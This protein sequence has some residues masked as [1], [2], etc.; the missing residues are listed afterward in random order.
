MGT[1][2]E[3]PVY[4]NLVSRDVLIL[5]SVIC[6]VRGLDSG[7]TLSYIEKSGISWRLMNGHRELIVTPGTGC[8]AGV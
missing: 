5:V 3:P 7:H 8:F 6:G 4:R 2:S 1:G